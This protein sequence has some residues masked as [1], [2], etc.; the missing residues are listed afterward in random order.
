[1]WFSFPIALLV[2]YKTKKSKTFRILLIII[3]II[4]YLSLTLSVLTQGM[5]SYT[6]H[7]ILFVNRINPTIQIIERSYGCGATD[8][9]FPKYVYYKRMP[10][11][12]F[13][14]FVTRIDINKVNSNDWKPVSN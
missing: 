14:D 13:L 2:N 5:C 11:I 9:E 12:S 6:T 3:G 10:L 1:M 7:R 8:S 4:A